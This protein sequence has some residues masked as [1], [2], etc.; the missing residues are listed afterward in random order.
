[1]KTVSF[2][3]TGCFSSFFLDYINQD[4]EVKPFV[5]DF[6]SKEAFDN[7]TLDVPHRKVLV[8][9]IKKQYLNSGINPPENI[10]FLLDDNTHTVT[11]GH[12]LCL[13]TGPL[14]FHYKIMSIIKLANS[15]C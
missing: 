9:S 4:N 15:Y 10:V 14:Y 12:Q 6:F 11:T 5:N 1:M 2:E 3:D 8:E 7:A 13:F